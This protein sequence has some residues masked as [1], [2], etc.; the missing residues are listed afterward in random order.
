MDHREDQ[1]PPPQALFRLRQARHAAHDEEWQ[2]SKEVCVSW[3]WMVGVGVPVKV[4][5]LD[6][7]IN[8]TQKLYAKVYKTSSFCNKG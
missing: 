5:I 8:D 3:C 6:I 7:N 2:N 1:Y 4:I